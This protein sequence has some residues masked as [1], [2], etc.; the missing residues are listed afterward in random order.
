VDQARVVAAVE[1]GLFIDGKWTDATGGRTF[2][3]VDPATG[4]T[5]CAVADASP[6]DGRAALDAAVA[7]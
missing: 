7:A 2:D 1:K 5:L 6:E 4:Q 3:V